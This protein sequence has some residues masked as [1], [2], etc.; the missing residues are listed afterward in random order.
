MCYLLPIRRA[1][2][3]AKQGHV[4][5]KRGEVCARDVSQQ[6]T[7]DI[8]DRQSFEMV[9]RRHSLNRINRKDHEVVLRCELED[10]PW[11]RGHVSVHDR[12]HHSGK[13]CKPKSISDLEHLVDC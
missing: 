1:V 5:Y 10:G 2:I 11:P 3:H 4:A 7:S 6:S 9:V 12:K 8:E 13:L